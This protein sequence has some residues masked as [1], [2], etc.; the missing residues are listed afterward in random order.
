[1]WRGKL[2]PPQFN[3]SQ[4]LR[5]IMYSNVSHFPS[6]SPT[7]MGSIQ[8]SGAR[9]VEVTLS[10]NP[11]GKIPSKDSDHLWGYQMYV[12]ITSTTGLPRGQ[13]ISLLL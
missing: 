6:K 3:Q 13:F 4:H 10:H 5:H 1:M 12:H 8:I 7:D 2:T 9:Q 11:P